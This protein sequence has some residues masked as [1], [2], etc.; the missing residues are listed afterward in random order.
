MIKY[1]TN[2]KNTTI[3]I[4]LNYSK[5]TNTKHQKYTKQSLTQAKQ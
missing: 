3:H 5:I 1:Q 4:N 2:A